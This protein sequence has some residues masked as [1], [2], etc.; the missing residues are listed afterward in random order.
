MEVVVY[1]DAY[2]GTT[3]RGVISE[4]NT[5]PASAGSLTT[6]DVTVIFEKNFPDEIMLAGM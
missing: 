5:I 6:Y 4:I 2:P 1:L 3:Y